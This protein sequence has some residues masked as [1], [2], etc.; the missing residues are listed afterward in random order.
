MD[1]LTGH[2]MPLSRS[3]HQLQQQL[4]IPFKDQQAA[5]NA[6][7]MSIYD[8]DV[9]N[10]DYFT[11]SLQSYLNK[12]K[13]ELGKLL[14]FDPILSDNNQRACASCHK[15]EMAFADGNKTSLGFEREKNL[16]RNAPTV[17]NAVFQ[18]QQFWDLRAASLEDQL[19]SVINNVDELHSSFGTL[20][21]KINSSHEY[22]QLFYE[23]FQEAKRDGIQRDHVKIAIASYER[24][25][26]GLDSRFDAFVRGDKSKLNAAEINGFN[27]F[28]GK[29]KCGSCHFAP[30]FNGALPPYFD[31][32]EHRS[33]G[34][35][36]QDSMHVFEVD[37]D[38]GFSKIR[39]TP[40]LLTK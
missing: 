39:P 18:K 16:L 14:F 34:V 22:R 35:P 5:L 37:P 13:S 15:P 12:A 40:A 31:S 36:L 27:L 17:V 20:I 3:F 1:F 26:T 9:F 2:L 19:D 32:T 28:M 30:L 25:L 10:P 38:T 8:K 6:Q 4:G 33:I 24:T 7:V 11:P 29:A 23:A 21:D